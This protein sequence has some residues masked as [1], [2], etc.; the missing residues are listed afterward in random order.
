MRGG[1]STINAI[2]K[3]LNRGKEAIKIKA[4]RLG[5]KGATSNSYKYITPCK[6]SK[7][8]GIDRHKV[9][10][11]INEGVLKAKFQAIC[12]ERKMRCIN[13]EDIIVY[14]EKNQSLWDSRKV[15]EYSLGYEYEWL[16]KKRIEDRRKN[17]RNNKNN[18]KYVWKIFTNTHI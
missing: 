2:Q 4:T 10:R 11:W 14:L 1:N 18:N 12:K 15:E 16:K 13:F 5:L 17:G 7:I 6:V 8:L 3:K 9:Y